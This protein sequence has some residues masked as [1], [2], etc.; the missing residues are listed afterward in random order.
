MKSEFLK[1]C[2]AIE[3]FFSQCSISNVLLQELI[4][5]VYWYTCMCAHACETRGLRYPNFSLSYHHVITTS[6][7]NCQ[8]FFFNF[9]YGSL[10]L[11]Y[12]QWLWFPC[13]PDKCVAR[14]PCNLLNG[15]SQ[16]TPDTRPAP[17]TTVLFCQPPHLS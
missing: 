5:S 9:L 17:S 14:G 2:S 13:Q 6:A 8:G 3:L 7:Y 10:P 4:T 1:E 16:L 12:F 15:I 11:F